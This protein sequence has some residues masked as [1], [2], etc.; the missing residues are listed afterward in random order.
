MCVEIPADCDKVL[1][2]YVLLAIQIYCKD[3]I[4]CVDTSCE[5]VK[6]SLDLGNLTR[7][8][9]DSVKEDIVIPLDR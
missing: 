6:A 1:L 5:E 2:W 7:F 8:L 3:I 9:L 4:Q